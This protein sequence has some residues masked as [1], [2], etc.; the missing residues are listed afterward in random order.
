LVYDDKIR[1]KYTQKQMAKVLYD[2]FTAR[3]DEGGTDLT[4]GIDCE[5]GKVFP[6][7]VSVGGLGMKML[8]KI[9]T[10]SV[11]QAYYDESLGA[12]MVALLPGDDKKTGGKTT[13]KVTNLEGMERKVLQDGAPF[14]EWKATG[15]GEIGVTTTIDRHT[16]VIR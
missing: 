11:G 10:V 13:F 5:V 8:D 12:L 2:Q 3:V 14:K 6:W 1:F 7:C 16:F 4:P 9:H 15:E